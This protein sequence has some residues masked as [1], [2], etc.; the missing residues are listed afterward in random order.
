V[1]RV[2]I[3]KRDDG[4]SKGIGFVCFEKPSEAQQAFDDAHKIEVDGRSISLNW[5]NE[6]KKEVETEKKEE[7]TKEET[8]EEEMTEKE[9]EE[10]T[11]EK[12]KDQE[13]TEMM[14]VERNSLLLLE[15]WD[16]EHQR[17]QLKNSS[18]IAGRL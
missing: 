11:E 5:A 10:T 12:E 4:K 18:V 16:I 6:K 17:E 13:D 7:D 8:E 9:E 15:I 1:T 3:L 2:N 14:M